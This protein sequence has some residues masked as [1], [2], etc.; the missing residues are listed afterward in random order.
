MV[1]PIENISKSILKI[2]V[3]AGQTNG[4]VITSTTYHG[5][6]KV[7]VAIYH[8]FKNPVIIATFS[9]SITIH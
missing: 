5:G 1:R 6:V 3:L 8:I 9:L 7:A 4:G 2:K